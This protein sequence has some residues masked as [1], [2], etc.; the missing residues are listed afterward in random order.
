MDPI[1]T[2]LD[3]AAVRQLADRLL[4]PS[5]QTTNAATGMGFN[6]SFIGF[7]ADPSAAEQAT[8]TTSLTFSARLNSFADWLRQDFAATGI[9]ILNDEG[10]IA[11]SDGKHESFLN[12]A[13]NLAP[14]RSPTPSLNAPVHLKIAT[15][16]NLVLIPTKPTNPR[17]LVAAL[18]PEHPQAS[19]FQRILENFPNP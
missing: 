4:N 12:L 16:V 7:E 13:R 3:P 1:H 2:W 17:F 14:S 8:P 6:D 18:I 10:I 9:F 15:K 5:P 11:F 19:T